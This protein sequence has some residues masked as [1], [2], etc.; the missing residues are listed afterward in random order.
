MRKALNLFLI[1]FVFLIAGLAA[2]T[3]L[4][5]FY[6]NVLNFIA[7]REIVLFKLSDV[8]KSFFFIAYCLVLLICPLVA[9]YRI[10]HPG[11]FAQTIAYCIICIITWC[12]LLPGIYYLN[13]YCNEKFALE[14]SYSSLS[15]GYFREVDGKIYYFTK[16]F[17]SENGNVPVTSAVVINTS[18]NGGVE[19]QTVRD[20]SNWDFNKKAYPYREIL[21][22]DNFDDKTFN[23][24]V[25][26]NILI[27][28]AKSCFVGWK[29]LFCVLSMALLISSLYALTSYFEWK[30]LN[31]VILFFGTFLVLCVNT[32][33]YYPIFDVVK[34]KIMNNSFFNM[35]GTYINEPLLFVLNTV[36]VLVCIILGIVKF[37]VHKHAE[38]ER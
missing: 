18:E 7:G 37:V 24:P 38:S 35:L 15:S 22:K 1:Y 2:G 30:L 17:E 19:Y 26:F 13:D 4:Y 33:Y 10:R 21:V 32:A 14:N 25:D 5:S 11:G 9:Y 31:T 23:L 20:L 34:H 3:V 28:S 12:C 8:L 36:F 6:L 27:N 16:E 29:Y